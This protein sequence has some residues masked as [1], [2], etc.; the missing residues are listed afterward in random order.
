MLFDSFQESR[1]I[2]VP[3]RTHNSRSWSARWEETA[4]VERMIACEA[5]FVYPIRHE[6]TRSQDG[7]EQLKRHLCPIKCSGVGTILQ[8]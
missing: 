2:Q 1:H 4:K 5:L 7:G 6:T 3:S 8:V